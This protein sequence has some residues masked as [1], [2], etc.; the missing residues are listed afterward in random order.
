MSEASITLLN[1][2]GTYQQQKQLRTLYSHQWINLSDIR[3]KNLF[4]DEAAYQELCRRI[5]AYPPTPVYFLGSGNFHYLSYY[6][7]S[8][9]QHPFTLLLFD[10][11]SDMLERDQLLTCGSWVSRALRTLP[12]LEQ[13]IIIG[14]HPHA[15]NA[16]QADLQNRVQIFSEDQCQPSNIDKALMHLS[17]PSLYIS[18]DKDVFSEHY[19]KTNWDQGSLTLPAFERILS[20]VIQR[21]SI[22]G[23][24]I[25]GEWPAT[26]QTQH[27]PSH[28]LFTQKNER[29][30]LALLKL[31][32]TINKTAPSLPF[33]N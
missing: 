5:E 16:I 14:T 23:I 25:C 9:L 2:D 17:T 11:H 21:F 13:V 8:Q 7:L 24:D 6:L 26:P 15:K 22:E 28:L 4:C 33:T 30:N 3:G 10:H 32:L 31:L 18:V 12:F 19:A 1:V 27:T 20:K 29:T